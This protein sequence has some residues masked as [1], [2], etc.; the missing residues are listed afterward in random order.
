MAAYCVVLLSA[1]LVHA[2]GDG[3]K[4]PKASTAEPLK[5]KTAKTFQVVN[6]GGKKLDIDVTTGTMLLKE[7]DGKATASIFY[8]AY[9]KRASDA[10]TRPVTFCFNGGPGSSSVW[11]HLGV[12]GPKRVLLS[13]DG[14]ALAAP[15]ET[16]G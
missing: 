13:D 1:T 5:E 3:P 4:M 10:A 8:V 15:R 14:E 2:Q 6:L 12:F 11:L 7:E 9:T 16:G